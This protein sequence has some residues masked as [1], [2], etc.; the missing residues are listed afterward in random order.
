MATSINI[1][2]YTGKIISPAYRSEVILWRSYHISDKES[3]RGDLD[4]KLE[5][6]MSLPYFKKSEQ[7]ERE[8][9]LDDS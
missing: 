5:K 6:M 1:R 8:L 2:L 9:S 7:L 4:F 3:D